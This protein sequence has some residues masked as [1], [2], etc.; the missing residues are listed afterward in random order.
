MKK[1][2]SKNIF[3]GKMTTDKKT[4]EYVILRDLK[5]LTIPTRWTLVKMDFEA[6]ERI[7][8]NTWFINFAGEEV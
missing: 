3:S 4:Q 2:Y 8:L 6:L 1:G 7:D 5:L